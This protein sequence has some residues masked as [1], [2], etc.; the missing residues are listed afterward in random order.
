MRGHVSTFMLKSINGY[1][2]PH[3]YIFL[4][5][6]YFIHIPILFFRFYISLKL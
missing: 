4:L 5:H 6:S 3:P 1:Y 2:F